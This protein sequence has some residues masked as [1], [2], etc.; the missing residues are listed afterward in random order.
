MAKNYQT[1]PSQIL[2]IENTY[3]AFCFDEACMHIEFAMR[4]EDTTIIFAD[5]RVDPLSGK[6]RTFQDELIKRGEL[7]GT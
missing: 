1:R 2:G 6:K 3:L 5:K 7:N 4:D